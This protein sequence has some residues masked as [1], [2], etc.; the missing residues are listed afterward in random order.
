ML[1]ARRKGSVAIARCERR[2]VGQV[3]T[4]FFAV[5]GSAHSVEH[6]V[7][8]ARQP[9]SLRPV[10]R[11]AHAP[12]PLARPARVAAERRAVGPRRSRPP[13]P[14]ARAPAASAP[15][16]VPRTSSAEPPR[17]GA[18]PAPPT[19]ACCAAAPGP[20]AGT[21]TPRRRGRRARRLDHRRAGAPTPPGGRTRALARRHCLT[22]SRQTEVWPGAFRAQE[23]PSR[24]GARTRDRRR[25]PREPPRP[26]CGSAG[27][28]PQ[29]RAREAAPDA[30]QRPS[31]R[32]VPARGFPPR[33]R[34]P[35]AA[36]RRVVRHADFARV[37]P[38]T[39]VNREAPVGVIHDALS[40][41]LERVA[42]RR[43]RR[44]IGDLLEL[45]LPPQRSGFAAFARSFVWASFSCARAP[46]RLDSLGAPAAVARF[47]R[48]RRLAHGSSPR[49]PDAART[50]VRRAGGRGGGRA[51]G[52]SGGAGGP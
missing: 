3:R 10:V 15:A 40:K 5:R 45:D 43:G 32:F 6:I 52:V 7:G 33:A 1:V 26:R 28:P 48:R 22:P 25:R 34:G 50:G 21:R 20:D 39:V 41:R 44:H 42:E 38:T 36:V 30:G 51:R 4:L 18:S 31:E 17:T 46:P 23:P 29:T 35:L 47:F 27:T 13:P 12:R 16:L 11:R 24:R 2:Q 14:R 9:A 37:V 49:T 8:S 19:H